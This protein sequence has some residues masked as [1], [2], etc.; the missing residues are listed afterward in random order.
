MFFTHTAFQDY[1]LLLKWLKLA[2][3]IPK[4]RRISKAERQFWL[5]EDRFN[6]IFNWALIGFF[7]TGYAA[8]SSTYFSIRFEVNFI[9]FV[10]VQTIHAIYS[11]LWMYL[12]FAS[13]CNLM[14]FYLECIRFFAL[15]FRQ[16]AELVERMNRAKR[17]PKNRKLLKVLWRYN[18][19]HLEMIE[20][21][22]FFRVRLVIRVSTSY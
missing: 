20:M 11:S 13:I 8:F 2:N 6:K 21:N 14:L 7:C 18:R 15:R 9:L 22:D 1:D 10:L 19:V 17:K 3:E 16:I 12:C 5:A 4:G